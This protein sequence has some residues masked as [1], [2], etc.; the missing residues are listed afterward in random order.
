M[1]IVHLLAVAVF[2]VCTVAAPATP[3]PAAQPSPVINPQNVLPGPWF[4]PTGART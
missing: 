1:R 4:T 2:V 3:A